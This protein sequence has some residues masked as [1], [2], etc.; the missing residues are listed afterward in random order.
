MP[1]KTKNKVCF[2]SC[3]MCDSPPLQLPTMTFSNIEIKRENSENKISKNI[4]NHYKS[5][6]LLD[7]K[8]LLKIYFSFID[9]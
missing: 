8:N 4:G 7:F 3:A 1:N 6:H 9:I 5:N 2:V